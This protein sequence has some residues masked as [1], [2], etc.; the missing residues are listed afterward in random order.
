MPSDGSSYALPTTSGIKT[1]RLLG[2]AKGRALENIR[3]A[4]PFYERSTPVYL[5]DYVTLD[6]LEAIEKQVARWAKA[7]LLVFDTETTGLDVISSR[8]VG[9]S[10]SVQAG[11]AYYIPLNHENLRDRRAEVLK[12]LKP[13]LEGKTPKAGHNMK[14]DVHMLAN[15]DIEAGSLAH[16]AA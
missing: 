15:E 1:W 9:L 13:L 14:F 2:K 8:I 10:F 3:F 6:T 5:G 12:A 11:E 4:H 7:P 16:A